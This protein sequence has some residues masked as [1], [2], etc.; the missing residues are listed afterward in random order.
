[1]TKEKKVFFVQ[2]FNLG[3]RKPPTWQEPLPIIGSAESLV[4]RVSHNCTKLGQKLLAEKHFTK[5]HLAEFGW[6]ST[7][8]GYKTFGQKHLTKRHLA[9]RHLAGN[10]LK[11]AT[12]LLAENYLAQRHLAE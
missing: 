11:L 7:K 1:V 4:G 6:Q 12:R 10:Q 2:L 5:R 9:E 3:D 8:I